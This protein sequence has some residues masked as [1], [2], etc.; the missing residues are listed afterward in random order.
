MLDGGETKLSNGRNKER[1]A[2]DWCSSLSPGRRRRRG[3]L[4]E[5]ER[6]K[7]NP[8]LFRQQMMKRRQLGKKRRRSLETRDSCPEKD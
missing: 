8:K 1:L 3:N 4:P 5:K 6:E 2:E 7:K